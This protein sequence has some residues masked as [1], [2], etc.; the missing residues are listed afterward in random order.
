VISSVN[1]LLLP[2]GLFTFLIFLASISTTPGVSPLL[3]GIVP[4]LC[5]NPNHGRP[6]PPTPALTDIDQFNSSSSLKLYNSSESKPDQ[7]ELFLLLLKCICLDSNKP[8][9]SCGSGTL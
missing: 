4:L 3:G 6:C 9:S 1:S 7:P 5:E 2:F 8:G